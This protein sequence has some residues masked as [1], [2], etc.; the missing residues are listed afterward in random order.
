MRV[1]SW[2][3]DYFVMGTGQRSA[4]GEV[5]W[6]LVLFLLCVSSSFGLF[7]G[8]CPEAH[9]LLPCWWHGKLPHHFFLLVGLHHPG[10]CGARWAPH[11]NMWLFL[12]IGATVLFM[13][14]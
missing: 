2:E 10:P 5:L 13:F 11:P 7:A 1:L 12:G 14:L 8:V 3:K 6:M 9:Q 4:G